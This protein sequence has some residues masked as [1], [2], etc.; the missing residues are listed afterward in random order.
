MKNKLKNKN[1]KEILENSNPPKNADINF[2]L[3]DIVNVNSIDSSSLSSESENNFSTNNIDNV[4]FLKEKLQSQESDIKYLESRLKNYDKIVSE[5]TRL[6][7]KIN[8]LN[9]I[10]KS[11][12]E[13]I[14]QFREIL[15]LT[16]QKFQIL[17]KKY[18]FCFKKLKNLKN[19]RN[20]FE[21]KPQKTIP[22]KNNDYND[23]TNNQYL[24]NKKNTIKQDSNINSNSEFIKNSDYKSNN[25]YKMKNF[26]KNI[27]QG[28]SLTP[29]NSTQDYR[30]K[31]ILR[32]KIDNELKNYQ[33]NK[34]RLTIDIETLKNDDL[35]YN[36][37]K[38]NQNSNTALDYSFLLLNNLKR[39]ITE[40]NFNYLNI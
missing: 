2:V 16:K 25:F 38:L 31:Y 7:I 9:K 21:L 40:N 34:K 32:N 26:N 8:K 14:K 12:N 24:K 13:T 1:N 17:L 3:K 5:V 33:F 28:R 39:N 23:Y 22:K 35:K 29:M 6:N 11:K 30:F 18:N 10:I 37:E 19:E 4:N 36:K 20:N 15:D 27:F